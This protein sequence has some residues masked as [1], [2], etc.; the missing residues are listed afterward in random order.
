MTHAHVL[1]GL[2]VILPGCLPESEPIKLDVGT[3]PA[4][5]G[6]KKCEPSLGETC[7][8]CKA[9]CPCCAGVA[10]A[11]SGATPQN[12]AGVGD[13]KFAELNGN[14]QQILEV[15]IGREIFDESGKTDFEIIGTIS[16]SG[17]ATTGCAST[18]PTTG[19][20]VKVLDEK[21]VWRTAGAWTSATG[22]NAFDLA[23]AGVAHTFQVR[24]EALG[25]TTARVDAVKATSCNE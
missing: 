25:N 6:D 3:P 8:N 19:V 13:G 23:C 4:S 11:G 24:L 20:V 21:E 10:A 22:G 12:A 15:T 1:A 18:L 5:C 7:L 14:E 17:S 2:L 16:G 9:D